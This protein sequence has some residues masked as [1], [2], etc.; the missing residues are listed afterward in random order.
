ME[1]L[2]HHLLTWKENG[3]QLILLIDCNTDIRIPNIKDDTLI[4]IGLRESIMYN[5]ED[6]VSQRIMHINSIFTSLT[7][8]MIQGG[9]LLFG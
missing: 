8:T 2:I 7:I 9:Y 4:E 1:D 5:R 3:D 6:K